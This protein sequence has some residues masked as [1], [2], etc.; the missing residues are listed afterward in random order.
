M[1]AIYADENCREM[2]Q[3]KMCMCAGAGDLYVFLAD[4]IENFRFQLWF[5]RWE[6][7]L[8]DFDI[9]FIIAVMLFVQ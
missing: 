8:N 1:S 5:V 3:T 9:L 2:S 6:N 4:A 7:R